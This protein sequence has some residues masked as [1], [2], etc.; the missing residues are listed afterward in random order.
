METNET[1]NTG[2]T[3]KVEQRIR[4]NVF[5]GLSDEDIVLAIKSENKDIE[6]KDILAL[7][8]SVKAEIEVIKQEIKDAR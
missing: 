3:E 2:I 6:V 4:R 1:A 7:I 8:R 5:T